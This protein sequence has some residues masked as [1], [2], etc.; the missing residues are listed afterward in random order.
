MQP[1]TISR[2]NQKTDTMAQRLDALGVWRLREG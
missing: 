2:S 1:K